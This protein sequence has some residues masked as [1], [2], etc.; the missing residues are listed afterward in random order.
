MSTQQT[1][2]NQPPIGIRGYLVAVF[3]RGGQVDKD[4]SKRQSAGT[5]WWSGR[6]RLDA[7]KLLETPEARRQ[8]KAAGVIVST[9]TRKG[10]SS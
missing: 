1:P 5:E 9:D 8:I 7:K 10:R 6:K 2:G 3:T 4:Q